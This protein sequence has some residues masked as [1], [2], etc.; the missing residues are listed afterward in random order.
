M[1]IFSQLEL[2]LLGVATVCD[3]V[4]LLIVLERINRPQVADWLFGLLCGLWLVHSASFLE[5]VLRDTQH[6]DWVLQG[7]VFVTCL[8]LMWLP[9]AMLHAALWLNFGRKLNEKIYWWLYLPLLGLLWV[10]PRIWGSAEPTLANAAVL[11]AN[12]YLGWVMV[13]NLL[14]IGLFLRVR[15]RLIN[16]G[17]AAFFPRLS[18]LLALM[19][20]MIL[21]YF[22]VQ[23]LAAVEPWWRM[24]LLLSP[25]LPALLF[26]WYS[27]SQRML[28]LVMERTLGYAAFLV[29]LLLMHRL[30]IDPLASAME[31]RAKLDVLLIEGWL[32]IGLILV[33]PPL[34]KRFREAVRYLLSSNVHQIRQV[35][36][37]LSVEM[38]QVAWQ[39]TD[40]L[41]DWLTAALRNGLEVESARIW[42]S[43]DGTRVEAGSLNGRS[44]SESKTEMQSAE[45]QQ[46]A[47][48]LHEQAEP[49]LVRGRRSNA[50]SDDALA[51]L[52]AM[53]A[54]R[55]HFRS[56]RG[57]VLLGPRMRS[58]RLADEQLTALALLFDQF[59]A[60]LHNRQ[61]EV[62]RL[63]AERQSMQQEKLSVLG[64][65]AGSL[66]HELRNPLSS[67]RT[68]ATLM[69]EDLGPAHPH[70]RDVGMIV[71][72]VDRLNQTT[73]RLLD[74][75][76]PA[77]D[78]PDRVQPDRVVT[79]L[80]YILEQLA[81]E[82][83]VRLETSL[84]GQEFK[85]AASDATLSEIL[86]NLIKNAIEAAGT[87]P[88][89]VS[90]G[91]EPLS[92]GSSGGLPPLGV[93]QVRTC[94]IEQQFQITVQDNGPGMDAEMQACMFE[95]FVTGKSDGTGLGLYIVSQRVQELAGTIRCTS[96]PG[97]GTQFCV[98][99]AT[100]S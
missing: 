11:V 93:V 87:P 100:C 19:T 40:Q 86:F 10:I 63:R 56:V 27:L 53:W 42:L 92:G 49:L 82:Y 33:Y 21:G 50:S 15:R 94:I 31:K 80:L 62:Q 20:L 5:A 73:Q 65:I 70:A 55:L 38:S 85:V 89:G 90:T 84:D 17:A 60:T 32:L 99:L 81:R 71:D 13:V 6:L 47:Q 48:T 37:N 22:Q 69:Q 16:R 1:E 52:G 98:Q 66:A 46:I 79:R 7:C 26:V 9:S 51:Q 59:A 75:S 14:A 4:L 45:L 97:A 64:L 58:D 36:R 78:Q 72:E 74:Y 61:L 96:E 34:R 28:P 25:L 24:A 8:G 91:S 43:Q 57:V 41:V 76:R 67:M 88:G 2:F 68:I 3:T 29:V 77:N 18:V 44:Q 83:R 95:P 23:G 12:W 30:L 35:T 39:S 54:F